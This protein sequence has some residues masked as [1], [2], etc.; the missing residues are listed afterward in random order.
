MFMKILVPLDLTDKHRQALAIARELAQQSGG[1]VTLLHVIEVIAGLSMDEE[2][3]FYSRLERA[4][5]AHLQRQGASLADHK[6]ALQHEILYGN[7]AQEIARYA[8]EAQAGLIVLT[9]PRIEPQDPTSWG[10]MS[11]KVGILA[12]CPVLLVK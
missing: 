10:S 8:T 9:A 4:A 1:E 3:G 12:R 7:R 11:Y 6:I 5:R 2:S